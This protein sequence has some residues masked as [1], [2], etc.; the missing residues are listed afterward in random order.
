MVTL[1]IRIAM[2]GV[3]DCD[4]CDETDCDHCGETDCDSQYGSTLE[5]VDSR[6]VGLSYA[7]SRGLS[8]VSCEQALLQNSVHASSSHDLA[9][10]H[11]FC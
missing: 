10:H 9:I 4:H 3:A 5:R 7:E 2:V 8:T 11:V 1:S 6:T